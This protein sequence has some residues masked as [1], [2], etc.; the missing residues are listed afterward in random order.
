[1]Q[2]WN[3][4][5]S[6]RFR[7]MQFVLLVVSFLLVV[8]LFSKFMVWNEARHG[9]LLNDPVL[10]LI[11]PINISRLT[12]IMTLI[13]IFTGLI[14]IFKKPESTIYFLLAAISIC[15]LRTLSLYFVVLEPPTNII[16]LE[17]PV[18]ERLF[19]GGQ[20]LLKDLFFSGHTANILLIGMLVDVLWLKRAIIICGI[21]VAMLLLIQHVHYSID[22]IAAPFF[23]M[24]AYKSSIN[25]GNYLLSKSEYMCTKTTSLSSAFGFY[26]TKDQIFK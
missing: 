1:M 8:F 11:R 26:K 18:I 12:S 21:F 13:P 23:A 25:M 17:D 7:S 15:V 4:Y 9:L 22:I 2:P 3:L 6:S 20:V 19:Y 16:P 24:I 5:M 14:F 10:N